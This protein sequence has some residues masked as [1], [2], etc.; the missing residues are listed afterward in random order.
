MA[1]M[2]ANENVPVKPLAQRS[3]ASSQGELSEY[4]ERPGM[5]NVQLATFPPVDRPPVTCFRIRGVVLS[6]LVSPFL[7]FGDSGHRSRKLPRFGKEDGVVECVSQDW[8]RRLSQ[9]KDAGRIP[10]TAGSTADLKG[11]SAVTHHLHEIDA[12]ASLRQIDL[13]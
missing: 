4:D 1:A 2:T 8:V 11:Q 13:Q 5:L 12:I 10:K 7:L 3:G 6:P 9:C